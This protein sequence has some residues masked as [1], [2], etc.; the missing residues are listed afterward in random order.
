MCFTNIHTGSFKF[1]RKYMWFCIGKRGVS[2][3]FGVSENYF[4]RNITGNSSKIVLGK[5][6]E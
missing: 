2:S 5:T 3:R 1:M 4:Q 6:N